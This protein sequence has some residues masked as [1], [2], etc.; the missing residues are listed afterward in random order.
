VEIVVLGLLALSI[1]MIA[2]AVTGHRAASRAHAD[3]D[4]TTRVDVLTGLPNRTSL[5]DAL[6]KALGGGAEREGALVLLELSRYAAIN[7]TYGREV[8]DGLLVA[9]AD[10]L[11]AALRPGERLFRPGGPQFAV[12]CP[13]L[14]SEHDVA[15]RAD[16]LQAALQVPFRIGTDH[17]RVATTAGA[18]LLDRRA[19]GSDDVLNDASTA[20][21]QTHEDGAPHSTVFTPSM[22]PPTTGRSAERRLREALEREEFWLLYLPV[23]TL[24]DLELVGVEALLRWAD[25]ERGLI[26]PNEFLAMLDESGLIIP[27]GD[28]VL[29]QACRQNVAWQRAFPDRELVTT[30]NI[31]PRQL[32]RPDFM[33]RVLETVH[34]TSAE[35]SRLCLEI[36]QG[37]VMRDLESSWGMLRAAKDAG[38]KLALDDFGT[39]YSSLA[40]L[41]SFSLD[42]LKID[43]T[44]V[45][46][47]ATSREDAAIAQQLVALAHALDLAPVAEGID[48]AEQAQTLHGMGCD[49]GQGYFFSPPQPVTSI[50]H[51]LTRRTV[52][53]ASD[54]PTVDW[55]GGGSEGRG[56]VEPL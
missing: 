23:V 29:E 21:R 30:I 10:Q 54:T 15:Q 2:V 34:E 49:F 53:P 39:G 50:D 14:T 32:A 26:G 11:T 16:E 6:T 3:L 17:L 33:D 31:S 45:R 36:T 37:M 40:Y 24:D 48:S 27:V 41:R 42:V 7:D 56:A 46:D 20:L 12:L 55:T 18:A 43:R 13:A 19:K 8:G 28:W 35:P 1:V 9:A 38:I 25:P 5:G 44:F 52:T 51:M 22:R 47:I 4:R